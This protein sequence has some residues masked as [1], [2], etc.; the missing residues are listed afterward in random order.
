MKVTSFMTI[1]LAAS[2]VTLLA[3]AETT[4]KPV[5]L[6][7][8]KYKTY[9]HKVHAGDCE[10]KRREINNR[11]LYK[12]KMSKKF[13]AT[14]DKKNAAICDDLQRKHDEYQT[15]QQQKEENYKAAEDRFNSCIK[16]SECDNKDKEIETKSCYEHCH[17]MAGYE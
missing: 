13:C 17:K 15:Q 4:A 16:Q 8:N 14:Q 10:Q 9:T 6:A 1:T 2:F 7:A 5:Q 3:Y 12:H 11:C